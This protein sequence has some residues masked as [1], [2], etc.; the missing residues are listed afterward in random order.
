MPSVAVIHPS[1]KGLSK[2]VCGYDNEIILKFSS[3]KIFTCDTDLVI[4]TQTA[5]AG[6]GEYSRTVIS[7]YLYFFTLYIASLSF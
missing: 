6:A 1:G 2:P 3:D 7:K 5:L 4:Y